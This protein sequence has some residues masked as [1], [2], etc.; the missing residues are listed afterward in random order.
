MGLSGCGVFATA[1]GT[2]PGRVTDGSHFRFLRDICK[3]ITYQLRTTLK[4]NFLSHVETE[5]LSVPLDNRTLTLAG[6]LVD[7]HPLRALDAIQLASA[8]RATRMLGEAMTFVSADRNLLAAAAAAAAEG[9][10]VDDPN[11]HP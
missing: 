4:A 11:A 8:I 9:F 7:K 10:A 3:H 6:D 5:Y 2:K 1:R